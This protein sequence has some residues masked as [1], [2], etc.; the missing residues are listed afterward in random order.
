MNVAF[1]VNRAAETASA[2]IEIGKAGDWHGFDALCGIVDKYK[3]HQPWGWADDAVLS[4]GRARCPRH[5]FRN[6]LEIVDSVVIRI[7]LALPR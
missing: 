4:A 1:G 7:A 6:L 3:N 5:Q 2:D